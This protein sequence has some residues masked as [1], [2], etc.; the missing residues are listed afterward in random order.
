MSDDVHHEEHGGHGGNKQKIVASSHADNKSR[1]RY[2]CLIGPLLLIVLLIP[3]LLLVISFLIIIPV[4]TVFTISGIQAF[5]ELT[6]V[7]PLLKYPD[8]KL[9]RAWWEGILISYGLSGVLMHYSGYA[10]YYYYVFTP[11]YKF[12][13]VNTNALPEWAIIS[14][15]ALGAFVLQYATVRYRLRYW[16]E[17]S[18]PELSLACLIAKTFS[19]ALWCIIVTINR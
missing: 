10:H 4:A 6:V 9:F 14:I 18:K 1:A 7:S 12:A 2:W 8:K 19:A 15:T 17:D 3:Q 16:R 13:P 5:L 11:N